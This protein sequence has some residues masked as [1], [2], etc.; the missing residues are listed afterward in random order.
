MSIT[1]KDVA[2]KNTN[3]GKARVIKLNFAKAKIESKAL[4]ELIAQRVI[5][6]EYGS[7][8]DFLIVASPARE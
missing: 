7:I 1:A 2:D 6:S 5:I 3:T 4:K 8:Q